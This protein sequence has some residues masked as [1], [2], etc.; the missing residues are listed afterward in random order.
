MKR[1]IISTVL[2][3]ITT[4]PVFAEIP[5]SYF[6]ENEHWIYD[7]LHIMSVE[8][9]QATLADRQPLSKGE[10]TE[11]F[12]ALEHA[13][14]QP[15]S[16]PLYREMSRYFAEQ[17]FLVS[18][19]YLKFDVNGIVAVQGQ[20]VHR[21]DNEVRLDSFLRYNRLP[22]LL[23]VPL[24]V[25]FTPYITFFG[26]I[27]LKKNYWAAELSHP[28]TNIPLEG[29]AFDAQFPLRGGIS[30]GGRFCNLTVGRG[31]LN[32]GR[33]LAGSMLLDDA[34]DRLDYLTASFFHK[35]VRLALN[36]VE[37]EPT[38][39]V[40]SHEAAFRPIDWIA[41]R[42]YEGVVVNAPFDPKYLNP[43]MIFHNFFG[44]EEE[45]F[46]KKSS[47]SASLVGCQLGF[48]ID[49]IPVR[50]LRLYGQYGQN[51][52]QTHFEK[53]NY[54]NAANIP[55]SLGGLAGIEYIYPTPVG[56]FCLT[57]EVL[58][59]NPWMYIMENKHISLYHRRKDTVAG[60]NKTSDQIMIWAANPYGPDTAGCFLQGS[61]T[62][63]KRYRVQCGYRFLAKGE[64]EELFFAKDQHYPPKETYDP[65]ANA[66]TPSG[67]AAY[68]H[69]FSVAGVHSILP[70]LELS[71]G[72]HWTVVH[73]KKNGHALDCYTAIK[74]AIR[75]SPWVYKY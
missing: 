43:M 10:L 11:Y 55:N 22:A 61:L 35:K 18:T 65:L 50:G 62:M 45:T 72:L 63:P 20:Y 47:G 42:L 51:Q 34:V 19:D 17:P 38:R 31:K 28:Y 30:F 52:F 27:A 68:F 7:A 26:D 13:D 14:I 3:C 73:G 8:S 69:T 37:L 74:Y 33:S 23:S 58:Y 2:I 44:W 25:M 21:P 60:K 39:F 48:G 75:D 5:Y 66:K 36:V 12:S 15:A 4:I 64:N 9:R 49:I 53:K 1:I 41:L 6:V 29:N 40:F 71:A 67:T 16:L 32:I 54:S 46:N 57:G 70:N 24:Q 59:A 56:H